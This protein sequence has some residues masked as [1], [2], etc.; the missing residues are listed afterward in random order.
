M[1]VN[2]RVDGERRPVSDT[3]R[4]TI[5]LGS[6]DVG[7]IDLLAG[8]ARASLNHSDFVRSAIRSKLDRHESVIADTARSRSLTLGTQRVTRQWL[9]ERREEGKKCA[10]RTIGSLSSAEDVDPDLA[11]SVIESITVFG[12]L[13]VSPTL[14]EVLA[15]RITKRPS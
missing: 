7:R 5:N 14:R 4:I 2:A 12:I 6:V 3:E 8:R 9:E 13:H 15:D 10:I 11:R 1:E